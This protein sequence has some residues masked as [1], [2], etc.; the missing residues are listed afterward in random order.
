MEP[1]LKT[2]LDDLKAAIDEKGAADTAKLDALQARFDEMDEKEHGAAVLAEVKAQM[3]AIRA[4]VPAAPVVPEVKHVIEAPN[5]NTSDT[6]HYKYDSVAIEDLAMAQMMLDQAHDPKQPRLCPAPASK[7]LR[8][9]IVARLGSDEGKHKDYSE[10]RQ[11]MFKSGV[12][13]KANELDHTTQAGFGNE[14]IGVAYSGVLWD[15]IRQNTQLADRIPSFA[16]PAGNESMTLPLEGADP[17]VYKVSEATATGTLEPDST[18][19]TSKL[20]TGS[21]SMTLGKFGARTIWSGEMTE[22]AV[23]AFAPQ[24][25]AQF[26]NAFADSFES[27]IFD[28]DNAAGATTNVNDIAGTPAGT[29]YWMAYDGMRVSALVTTSANSRDGGVLTTADFLETIKLMGAA[30]K[31]ALDRE[32]V[33]FYITPGVHWKAL[34]LSDVKSR[35]VFSGATIENG[36]LSS[37]YGYKVYVSSNLCKPDPNG[38]NLANANGKIDQDTAG[39]NTTGT[40]LAARHDQ[41]RIGYRR[42]VTLET[43]R[44]ARA[45]SFELVGLMRAGLVQ[46]DTE[47][48]AVSYNITV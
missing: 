30:G 35:D 37:I 40:I 2:F 15:S 19:T 26:A 12:H 48:A 21:V 1:E 16:F 6:S 22:D 24:L 42:N 46:R 29:E 44:I 45:D 31:N 25:R 5:L 10:A 13:E 18:V 36:F 8:Q 14:W 47:A 3:D 34:E 32:K 38:A 23:I 33:A 28:G 43:T 7:E 39:N 9:N 11:L 27:S 17:T 41:W 4:I 20:G